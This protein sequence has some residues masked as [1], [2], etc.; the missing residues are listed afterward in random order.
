MAHIPVHP[1]VWT[2]VPV[3]DIEAAIAFYGTV[4]GW[5]MTLDTSGPNPMAMF[6]SQDGAGVAGHLYPGTPA[7]GGAGNTI[8]FAVP[9]NLEAAMERC[10]DAGGTV[11]SP[12][13]S[14]PVGRFAY[15]AD[16]DGNSIGLFEA[17]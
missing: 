7:K 8:H 12:P 1:V 2:E 4:F 9:D 15:V 10:R 3:T 11:I 17:A 13:I 6:P 14:L 16:P 5:E